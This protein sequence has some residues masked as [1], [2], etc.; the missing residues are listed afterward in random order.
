M[1]KGWKKLRRILDTNKLKRFSLRWLKLYYRNDEGNLL[2]E[3]EVI[4]K[5]RQEYFEELLNEEEEEEEEAQIILK[6]HP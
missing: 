5:S 3:A 1:K 6:K 4:T 2:S